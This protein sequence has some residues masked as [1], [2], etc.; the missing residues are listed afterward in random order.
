MKLKQS[1]IDY[2]VQIIDDVLYAQLDRAEYDA[3]SNLIGVEV[4]NRLREIISEAD[5]GSSKHNEGTESDRRAGSV[6]QTIK[7]DI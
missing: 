1:D 3:K 5:H 2:L 6:N 7:Q 4:T